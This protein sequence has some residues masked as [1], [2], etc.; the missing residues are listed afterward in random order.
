MPFWFALF[1][2]VDKRI[3]MDVELDLDVARELEGVGNQILCLMEVVGDHIAV[4]HLLHLRPVKLVPV[5][6]RELVEVGGGHL[7]LARVFG[8][9]PGGA[10]RH[11]LLIF[12][13]PHDQ[14]DP[15]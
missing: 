2:H 5:G 6:A 14:H 1:W 7:E 3:G 9:V 8:V 12:R 13:F 10:R 11:D 15:V 4:V